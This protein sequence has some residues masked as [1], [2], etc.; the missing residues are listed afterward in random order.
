MRFSCLKGRGGGGARMHFEEDV[1]KS[2][3]KKGPLS[4]L[5][6]RGIEFKF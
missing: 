5:L 6:V 1:A 2:N 3:I 4:R